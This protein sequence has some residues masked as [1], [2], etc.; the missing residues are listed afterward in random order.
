MTP[1]DPDGATGGRAARRRAADAET[2]VIPPVPADPAPQPETPA[3]DDPDVEH[4]AAV[5]EPDTDSTT[6]TGTD[7]GAADDV[8]PAPRRGPGPLRRRRSGR[9]TPV[10]VAAAA[11]AALAVGGVLLA[12]GVVAPAAPQPAAVVAPVPAAP[13]APAVLVVAVASEA[14]RAER[15]ADLLRELRDADVPASRSGAAEA[16]AADL[17]C[18]ELADGED[19]E[20]IAQA[21]PSA[22]PTV[23]RSQAADLVTIAEEHYC[24]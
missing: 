6:D 8:R 13:V 19:P 20:R 14:E 11:G 9:R 17:V 10:V 7:G 3:A 16:G 24:A 12:S 15:T 23:N 21:L 18:E 5:H 1:A 22:L 2:S 4:D